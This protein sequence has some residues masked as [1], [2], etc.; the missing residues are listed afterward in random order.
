[1]DESITRGQDAALLALVTRA[2]ASVNAGRDPRPQ[3]SVDLGA[4]VG[5][6]ASAYVTRGS[7]GELQQ[8]GTHGALDRDLVCEAFALVGPGQQ[9]F[10]FTHH[11]CSDEACRDAA[12]LPLTVS[13]PR[14]T[15]LVF[16]GDVPD[17]GVLESA[18]G[19]LREI[20]GLLAGVPA[21]RTVLPEQR[22]P[23]L[24]GSLTVRELEVLR[25][26]AEGLLARTIAVRLELSPRTVHHHLGSIYDKLGVR[27]RLAAVLHAREQ[28]LLSDRSRTVPGSPRPL[29]G[30]SPDRTS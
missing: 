2:L 27:D 28:G 1:M 15:A 18:G 16:A 9:P 30:V 7:S 5:S 11:G 17:T 20:D 6:E 10:R 21:P 4:L 24:S 14:T 25:L 19:A 26:L 29:A 13:V 22:R 3:I 8:S 23:S 12:C